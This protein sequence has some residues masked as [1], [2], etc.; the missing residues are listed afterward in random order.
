[1]AGSYAPELWQRDTLDFPPAS[2]LVVREDDGRLRSVRW[3]PGDDVRPGEVLSV[4]PRLAVRWHGWW[5]VAAPVGPGHYAVVPW[6]DWSGPVRPLPEDAA[7]ELGFGPTGFFR[8]P[9]L[10]LR[11]AEAEGVRVRLV[12]GDP[13]SADDPALELA[14]GEDLETLTAYTEQLARLVGMATPPPEPW[15]TGGP[16]SPSTWPTKRAEF[17]LGPTADWRP[18]GSVTWGLNRAGDLFPN[19]DLTDDSLVA[20][21]MPRLA[22]RRTRWSDRWLVAVAEAPDRYTLLP[23]EDAPLQAVVVPTGEA[24]ELGVWFDAREGWVLS[25]GPRRVDC[26]HVRVRL[27]PA[28]PWMESVTLDLESGQDLGDVFADPDRIRHA[29]KGSAEAKS[30]WR[31]PRPRQ[32]VFSPPVLG[33]GAVRLRQVLTHAVVRRML[34]DQDLENFSAHTIQGFVTRSDDSAH[35]TQVDVLRR[36]LGPRHLSADGNVHDEAGDDPLWLLDGEIPAAFQ[37][38]VISSESSRVGAAADGGPRFAAPWTGTGWTAGEPPL[39]EFVVEPS[40]L[41]AG[42]TLT[43]LDVD[44]GVQLLGVLELNETGALGWRSPK[45]PHPP[46]QHSLVAA[47]TPWVYLDARGWWAA[48]PVAHGVVGVRACDQ[49]ALRLR[50]PGVEARVTSRGGAWA[51]VGLAQWLHRWQRTWQQARDLPWVQFRA[52]PELDGTIGLGLVRVG[53]VVQSGCG[54]GVADGSQQLGLWG[55]TNHPQST[56]PTVEILPRSSQE[57][58]Q[59]LSTFPLPRPDGAPLLWHTHFRRL[60]SGAIVAVTADGGGLW[61]DVPDASAADIMYPGHGGLRAAD[62]RVEVDVARL[63]GQDVRVETLAERDGVPGRVIGEHGK[64]LRWHPEGDPS[65]EAL[66]SAVNLRGLRDVVMNGGAA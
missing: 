26:P 38:R 4:V 49:R 31:A 28:L 13:R 58:V 46:R 30:W 8:P 1:M 22:V 57:D 27:V 35:V 16:E 20:A 25:G 29:L 18:L 40:P 43:R 66:V 53:R 12:G 9:T 34:D 24:S 7:S 19:P 65:Q 36:M 59:D 10:T 62:G 6:Q 11:R 3:R 61:A 48:V 54:W 50:L 64:R 39:R 15:P 45:E 32:P 44:E 51:L 55:W 63:V 47:K 60:A 37:D 42:A 41:L 56:S 33:P 52:A 17:L 2:T 23:L 14:V 5:L 21:F